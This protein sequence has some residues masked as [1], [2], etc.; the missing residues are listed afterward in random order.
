M[1]R[2][3]I[4]SFPEFRR[5]H[6]R[7][8]RAQQRDH[9]EVCGVVVVKNTS[10]HSLELKFL[11]NVSDHAGSFELEDRDIRAARA[12]AQSES[13]RLIGYFHSHPVGYATLG[14]RDRRSTPVNRVHLVYDVC[15]REPKLWRMYK[16][17]GRRV[18]KGLP[19]LVQRSKG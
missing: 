12:A 9:S 10:A 13:K 4:L 7:A 8:Y 11:K 17:R 16:R 14:P 18:V 19:L 3:Y 2:T 1:A 15:S 5:L 6:A